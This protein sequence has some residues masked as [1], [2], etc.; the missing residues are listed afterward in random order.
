MTGFVVDAHVHLFPP[1]VAQH[2]ERYLRRDAWFGELYQ[3]PGIRFATVDDLIGSMDRSG[4]ATS[5]I[6]GWPWK[7]QGLCREHNAFLAEVGRNHP[8][9]I[10]WLAIVN[11]TEPG[12]VDSAE[13]AFSLGAVG[14]GELNADA[15]GFDWRD[16]HE[17]SPIAELC[18]QRDQPLLM[19]CSEP[20]GHAYPGK[21]TATPDRIVPFFQ[22]FPDLRVIAAHWGGGLPFYE[23]MPEIALATRNV[24]YD[25]AA[26]TFLYDF[27]I[28][29]VAERLLEDGRVMF[30]TDYPLLKQGPFLRR[31]RQS[32]IGDDRLYDFLGR[33]AART[34]GF[35]TEDGTT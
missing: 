4:I 29:Q 25:T 15:Q 9:R 32:G 28:L 35:H 34:F 1:D 31:V 7:D 30:G 20:V 19:H 26:S 24:T 6:C 18:I 12:A 2:R 16:Q 22:A 10:A 8:G 11:P 17:M 13:G 3:A 5:V 33:T 23:L 27:R 14:L 21:G